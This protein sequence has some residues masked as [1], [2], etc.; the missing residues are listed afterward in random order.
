MAVTGERDLEW[1]G[2]VTG[3]SREPPCE[4][5]VFA[6]RS[7][8]FRDFHIS[9]ASSPPTAERVGPVAPTHQILTMARITLLSAGFAFAGRC[10]TIVSMA[11]DPA[12]PPIWL[13]K[14]HVS[15]AQIAPEDYAPTPEEGVLN[16][17]RLSD[18]VRAWSEACA[19]ALGHPPCS[20]RPPFDNP[21]GRT[22]VGSS[23]PIGSRAGREPRDAA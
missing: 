5:D 21:F 15:A 1:I 12:N 10:S 14:L 20:P 23:E 17:C 6:H 9:P 18:A 8:L 4:R 3:R 13:R 19:R 7:C 2:R 22:A 16:G 11:F